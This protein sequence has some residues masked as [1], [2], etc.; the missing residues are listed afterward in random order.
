M[1]TT[2]SITERSILRILE[3]L[4]VEGY[5][6]RQ[7]TGKRNVYKMKT[8]FITKHDLTKYFFI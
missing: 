8:R 6:S 7:N 2:L 3:D 1:A 4:E 5:I